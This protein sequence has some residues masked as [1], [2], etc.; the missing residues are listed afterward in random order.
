MKLRQVIEIRR[1]K[2]NVVLML[3]YIKVKMSVRD[4]SD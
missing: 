3:F 4:N 1:E 2:D